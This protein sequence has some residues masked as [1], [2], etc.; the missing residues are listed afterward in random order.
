MSEFLLSAMQASNADII[1]FFSSFDMLNILKQKKNISVSL[2]SDELIVRKI[3]RGEQGF[4]RSNP[5]RNLLSI[6]FSPRP[7]VF[8]LLLEDQYNWS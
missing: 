3:M 6:A 2:F 4:L 8:L 1:V 7:D 5:S